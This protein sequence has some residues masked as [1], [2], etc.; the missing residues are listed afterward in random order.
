MKYK[1][2]VHQCTFLHSG[3]YILTPYHPFPITNFSY[4][5][6]DNATLGTYILFLAFAAV[7][8]SDGAM[9]RLARAVVPLVPHPG[10]QRGHSLLDIK[11][12]VFVKSSK[13]DS[14]VKEVMYA[15]EIAVPRRRSERD[16][17]ETSPGGER[18]EA[19]RRLW[20]LSRTPVSVEKLGAVY[21]AARKH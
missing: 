20:T 15:D 6:Q 12:G 7:T 13:N 17:F 19:S 9:A 5:L 14:Y 4:V 1:I 2:L 11:G 10:I 3:F 21:G 8:S 18:H 16:G